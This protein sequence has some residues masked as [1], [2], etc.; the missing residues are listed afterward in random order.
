MEL[1]V[2]VLLTLHMGGSDQVL[3]S[4]WIRFG[5]L[6]VSIIEGDLARTNDKAKEIA[7]DK[8]DGLPVSEK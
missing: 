7:C 4:A 1:V 5:V 2:G 8:K 6:K 3:F